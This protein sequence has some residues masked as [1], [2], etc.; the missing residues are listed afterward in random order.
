M[1]ST[2]YFNSIGKKVPKGAKNNKLAIEMFYKSLFLKENDAEA[3]KFSVSTHTTFFIE[4]NNRSGNDA[5]EII[6][7]VTFFMTRNEKML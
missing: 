6:A 4:I 5:G 3:I 1:V 2:I 7:A